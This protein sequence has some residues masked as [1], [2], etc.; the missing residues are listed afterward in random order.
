MFRCFSFQFMFTLSL[1]VWWSQ[2]VSSGEREISIV[3]LFCNPV[4]YKKKKKKR[5]KSDPIAMAIV[6]LHGSR[7]SF[8]DNAVSLYIGYLTT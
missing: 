6:K 8:V 2:L 5:S 7:C 1:L 3:M 4:Y